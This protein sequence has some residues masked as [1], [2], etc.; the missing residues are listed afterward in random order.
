MLKVKVDHVTSSP[1]QLTKTVDDDDPI[2]I[3][4]YSDFSTSDTAASEE[5]DST[6]ADSGESGTSIGE[7][8]NSLEAETKGCGDSGKAELHTSDMAEEDRTAG[9]VQENPHC[10]KDDEP[11]QTSL[12]HQEP[13]GTAELCAETS[14]DEVHLQLEMDASDTEDHCSSAEE[15]K[16]MTDVEKMTVDNPDVGYSIVNEPS[17]KELADTTKAG[18][19]PEA[20]PETQ[21]QTSGSELHESGTSGVR[22]TVQVAADS[23]R[24]GTEQFS[25]DTSE[26]SKLVD[27]VQPASAT[28]ANNSGPSPAKTLHVAP[29]STQCLSQ[30]AVKDAAEQGQKGQTSELATEQAVA[31]AQE[32]ETA[33]AA[34]VIEPAT[35]TLA[36]P[37]VPAVSEQDVLGEAHHSGP[38]ETLHAVAAPMQHASELPAELTCDTAV[39]HAVP[40]PMELTADVPM[41]HAPAPPVGIATSLEVPA[42]VEQTMVLSDTKQASVTQLDTE[43]TSSGVGPPTVEPVPVATESADP[44]KDGAV[45]PA[46]AASAEN[47]GHPPMQNTVKSVNSEQ[48]IQPTNPPDIDTA[49]ANLGAV[50]PASESAEPPDLGTAIETDLAEAQHVEGEH[51][52]LPGS[53]DDVGT[54]TYVVDGGL[55]A[56]PGSEYYIVE[57]DVPGLTTTGDAEAGADGGQVLLINVSGEEELENSESY[58]NQMNQVIMTEALE[59]S[60]PTEAHFEAADA[61][62]DIPV[63]SQEVV[64]EVVEVEVPYARGSDIGDMPSLDYAMQHGLGADGHYLDDMASEPA[65]LPD[66]LTNDVLDKYT[67]TSKESVV[68]EK[69][70]SQYE[71]PVIKNADREEG[72][73]MVN[74]GGGDHGDTEAAAAAAAA[75]SDPLSQHALSAQMQQVSINQGKKKKKRDPTKARNRKSLKDSVETGLPGAL[76]APPVGVLSPDLVNKIPLTSIDGEHKA[77]DAQ[78]PQQSSPQGKK[79][80]KSRRRKLSPVQRQHPTIATM[81]NSA[82]MYPP[83]FLLL[84]RPSSDAE[85]LAEEALAGMSNMMSSGSLA[86][87]TTSEAYYSSVASTAAAGTAQQP[88]KPQQ[89][90]MNGPVAPAATESSVQALLPNSAQYPHTA[91]AIT[92]ALAKQLPTDAS[93]LPILPGGLGQPGTAANPTYSQITAPPKKRARSLE[94]G[95]STAQPA[96]PSQPQ[97]PNLLKQKKSPKRQERLPLASSVASMVEGMISDVFTESAT[98][99][100]KGAPQQRHHT[101]KATTQQRHASYPPA[102]G[103]AQPQFVSPLQSPVALSV[104]QVLMQDNVNVTQ[105]PVLSPNSTMHAMV[106]NLLSSDMDLTDESQVDQYMKNWRPTGR[107]Q[108]HFCPYSSVTKNY[109]FRHWLVNHNTLEA[110][111]CGYCDKRATY[112]DSITRH[113]S[114]NHRNMDKWVLIDAI[115]Q[116]RTF[117]TFQQIF[118]LQVSLSEKSQGSPVLLDHVDDET[119]KL[120]Q[121][122]VQKQQ[123][124]NDG[125]RRKSASI[126]YERTFDDTS[127]GV[128]SNPVALPVSAAH[129]VA[130]TRPNHVE[131]ATASN[132]V[133]KDAALALPVPVGSGSTT[134]RSHSMTLPV[135]N[136]SKLLRDIAL[137]QN[138]E[139][140]SIIETAHYAVSNVPMVRKSNSMDTNSAT[141]T[142]TEYAVQ[143][144]PHVVKNKPG[145]AASAASTPY[146]GTEQETALNLSNKVPPPYPGFPLPGPSRLPLPLSVPLPPHMQSLA[147]VAVPG[148]RVQGPSSKMFVTEPTKPTE[149]VM[150]QEPSVNSIKEALLK[151]PRHFLSHPT[152]HMAA[153]VSSAPTAGG[154]PVAPPRGATPHPAVA[155]LRTAAV[156]IRPPPPHTAV[157]GVPAGTA[158]TPR[159][160]ASLSAA[161]LPPPASAPLAAAA[162][163]L[164]PVPSLVPA[165]VPSVPASAPTVPPRAAAV[166]PQASRPS[167]PV[168]TPASAPQPWLVPTVTTSPHAFTVV[169]PP[170]SQDFSVASAASVLKSLSELT[171]KPVPSIPDRRPPAPPD[172]S[173]LPLMSLYG[174]KIPEGTA[175]VTIPQPPLRGPMLSP[176]FRPDLAATAPNLALFAGAFNT[177]AVAQRATSTTSP[178]T[179]SSTPTSKSTPS[180]A[181]V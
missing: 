162:A 74:F 134:V 161:S 62:E 29:P 78:V 120:G 160:V 50:F 11:T 114:I 113:Q 92:Q 42:S 58:M 68:V 89:H 31:S 51:V 22:Q 34:A 146:Y 10:S 171:A 83:P 128:V 4:R 63:Q 61:L 26:T 126:I 41:E 98:D 115:I 122:A 130:E 33:V 164:M 155:P 57:G 132:G 84:P 28:T 73:P 118:G 8:P 145:S 67:T 152:M 156:P 159:H 143:K 86:G 108:C 38:A 20:N 36:E 107:F 129:S 17:E 111:K 136:P 44:T 168:T 60:S 140:R 157:S 35:S 109:L 117:L 90:G 150:P 37:L 48:F 16:D 100:N 72:E 178:S 151:P 101:L 2:S 24:K 163:L 177:T 102:V 96:I 105:A 23:S 154:H 121:E 15:A 97:Q 133:A 110:Y 131:V 181:K 93:G 43:H 88:Q 5:S 174:L 166:A 77:G 76:A 103:T 14:E 85:K 75:K 3:G 153:G 18:A 53:T 81:L 124:A 54:V 142:T 91:N 125:I 149:V 167:V 46:V 123:N 135:R 25:S 119:I 56:E 172:A 55:D 116:E 39:E 87:G 12:G 1:L 169:E 147:G 69:I 7:A 148:Q 138:P 175:G 104:N 94:F 32:H 64:E 80:K 59:T 21:T 30:T 173:Q 49:P 9:S 99:S 95:T 106:R 52:A 19:F 82:P 27:T 180:S 165:T 47:V 141:K 144:E 176:T 13:A 179:S 70:A 40:E 45:V 139:D 137:P 112:R 71:I 158:P 79:K 6:A 66:A 127:K 65:D 170:S